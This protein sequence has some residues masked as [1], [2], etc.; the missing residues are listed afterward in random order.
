[1]NCVMAAAAPGMTY[2]RDSQ[3]QGLLMSGQ[4]TLPR[5]NATFPTVY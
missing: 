2:N 3:C 5:E 1:M 4:G